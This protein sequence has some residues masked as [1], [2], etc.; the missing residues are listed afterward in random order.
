MNTCL[1]YTLTE[2]QFPL[3]VMQFRCKS[4]HIYPQCLP[5]LIHKPERLADKL[6][7]R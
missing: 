5:L 4:V 2:D 1:K 3:L 6:P 7:G